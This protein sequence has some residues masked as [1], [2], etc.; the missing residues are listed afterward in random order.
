MNYK[1]FS[2]SSEKYQFPNEK[3]LKKFLD[4]LKSGRHAIGFFS[5][6]KLLY[7]C[8]LSLDNF[9]PKIFNQQ[10]VNN[11]GMVFDVVCHPSFRRLGIH[12]YMTSYAINKAFEFG[13]SEVILLA[14]TNN[15][16]AIKSYENI[17]FKRKFLIKHRKFLNK[18]KVERCATD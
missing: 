18:N 14:N 7:Y 3:R 2:N 16:A 1:D 17:G 8:W 9:E 6:K 10:L 5:N 11:Q 15:I 4:R 13:K 12:K